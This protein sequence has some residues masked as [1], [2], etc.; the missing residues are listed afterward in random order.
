MLVGNLFAREQREGLFV[1]QRAVNKVV[2]TVERNSLLF[3]SPFSLL[4]NDVVPYSSCAESANS[5][6][7]IES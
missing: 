2:V 7:G 1:G 4:E 5:E 3:E 6:P